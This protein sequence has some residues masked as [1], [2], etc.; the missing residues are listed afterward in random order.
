MGGFLRDSLLRGEISDF[1]GLSGPHDMD[2][3]VPPFVESVESLGHDLARHLGGVCQPHNLARDVYQVIV[4]SAG[5]GPEPLVIDLVRYDCDIERDMERRDFTVNAMA[6]PMDHPCLLDSDP[7]EWPIPAGLWA[8]DL[9]DPFGGR[10]DVSRKR[11]R[12]V[13][14]QVFRYDPGRLL[15]GVRLA[16]R[17]KFMLEPESARLIRRQAH[18]LESVAPERVRSEFM[19]ILAQDGARAQLEV[20]DRLD[21]LCRI[22]PELE[23]TKGVDQPSAHYW[24]VWDHNLHTVEYA[25][26]ITRGHQNS[27]IYSLAPWNAEVEAYFDEEVGDGFSRRT[28][29]KLAGLLHDIAKP[30]TKGPDKTGRI[31]FLGHSELGA[32]MVTERLTQ[33]RFSA[34][35]V[36]MVARMVEHH[37]RPSQLRHGDEQPT[38]RAVHR[39]YRDVGDVAVDTIYLAMADY[40]A[41]KGP[42]VVAE[43]WANHAR[44]LGDLLQAG[45]EK[46]PARGPQRLLTGHDLMQHLDL[47]PG[48]RIGRLLAQ[49]DEARAAGE[50]A[51]REEA[52]SLAA[53]LK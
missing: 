10:S 26:L 14:D 1:A 27:A 5:P 24:D 47:P 53:T 16:G 42:E 32:E 23:L 45:R 29:L 19:A 48:P 50:I 34:R 52:L 39:Y 3:A 33:L 31:R 44:M 12:V 18:L 9:V 36:A 35:I 11:I 13:N 2:I 7:D 38:P 49:I 8:S 21:L 17:L 40:L 37:L 15:R 30:Q 22:I 46:A 20:L 43:R 41:A 25:E 51:T 28:V 4:K 6:L